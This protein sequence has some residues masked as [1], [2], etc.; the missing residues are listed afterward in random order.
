[1]NKR[2]PSI[3]MFKNYVFQRYYIVCFNNSKTVKRHNSMEL[4]T[5]LSALC[6]QKY[7]LQNVDCKIAISQTLL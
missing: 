5:R 4:S 3:T 6:S 1:M 2:A 7:F